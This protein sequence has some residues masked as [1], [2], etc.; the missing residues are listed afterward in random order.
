MAALGNLAFFGGESKPMKPGVAPK[1][2]D[3]SEINPEEMGKTEWEVEWWRNMKAQQAELAKKAEIENSVA[4][5]GP[6]EIQSMI[7]TLR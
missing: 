3:G 4:S 5:L 2:Y 1:G 7:S 6:N